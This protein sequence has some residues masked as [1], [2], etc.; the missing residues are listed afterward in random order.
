MADRRAFLAGSCAFAAGC[1]AKMASISDGGGEPGDAAIS[2][3]TSPASGPGAGY[4]QLVKETAR[5][6]GGG[7]LAVGQV[8]IFNIDYVNAAIIAR[9]AGGFYALSAICTHQCCLVSACTDVCGLTPQQPQCSETTPTAL[10][11]SG[12]AFICLCHGSE[13][14]ADGAVTRGPAP[15]R[16]P[17]FAL[18]RDGDDMLVDFSTVVPA[19]TRIA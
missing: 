4:C 17:A 3:T 18:T 12:P 6:T 13:Y 7:T 8:M 1:A 2:C 16:L 5:V 19:T 11:A 9:D 10:V 15:N 14:A